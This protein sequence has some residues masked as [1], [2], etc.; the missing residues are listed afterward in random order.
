MKTKVAPT[1]RNYPENTHLPS[2]G[3]SMQRYSKAGMFHPEAGTSH[4]AVKPSHRTFSA[5]PP[6]PA[7]NSG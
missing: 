6:R 4:S 1:V 7:G 3:R 5:F 2:V